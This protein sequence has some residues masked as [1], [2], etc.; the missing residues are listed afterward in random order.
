MNEWKFLAKKHVT[1]PKTEVISEIEWK[2]EA[3]V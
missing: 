3:E 1:D 2:T